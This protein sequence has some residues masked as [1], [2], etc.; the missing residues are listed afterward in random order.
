MNKLK[1]D[2]YKKNLDI[3]NIRNICLW[4]WRWLYFSWLKYFKSTNCCAGARGRQARA[5][6]KSYRFWHVSKQAHCLV[7][8]TSGFSLC[9]SN[10]SFFFILPLTRNYTSSVVMFT[11]YF[12]P[13]FSYETTECSILF[14]L[15][16]LDAFENCAE[17]RSA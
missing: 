3:F 14:I 10:L 4:N 11:D 16:Q 2:I 15:K 7:Q 1:Q 6:F 17:L 5:Q 13:L 12:N 9:V 8:Q